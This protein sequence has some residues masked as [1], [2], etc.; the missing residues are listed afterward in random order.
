MGGLFFLL[1]LI[2]NDSSPKI[3]INLEKGKE[4]FYI[5]LQRHCHI[6]QLDWKKRSI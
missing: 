6:T 2:G 5:D 3:D 1:C 4:N